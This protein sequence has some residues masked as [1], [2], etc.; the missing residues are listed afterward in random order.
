[1]DLLHETIRAHAERRPSKTALI[2]GGATLGYADLERNVRRLAGFLAARFPRGTRLG[3]LL[4]N[5]ASAVIG[6]YA[7]SAAGLVAVP[8]DADIHPRHADRL[9]EDCQLG[10]MLTT[11][12]CLTRVPLDIPFVI[13]ADGSRPTRNRVALEPILENARNGLLN[14]PAPSA[15]D[16]ACVLYTAGTTGRPKG[17]MLTHRNL[18]AAARN[19]IGFM[20]LDETVVES[21]PTRLSHSFGFARLRSVL[22]AGGTALLEPGFLRPERL[23]Q[24]LR[25]LGA[26]ALSSS[27]TGWAILLDHYLEAFKGLG[28]RLRFIEIG[29]ARLSRRHR[30]M[31]LELCPNARVVMH[32]GLTES[33]RATFIDLRTEG[34]RWGTAG[35]PAPGV[36][37][38]V[39]RE[40]GAEAVRGESGE[41]M[42]RAETNTPGYW[43]RADLTAQAL[44]NGWLRT[45]DLGFVDPDGYLHLS[46]RAEEMINLGGLKVSPVEVEEVLARQ[47]AIQE[48]AVVGVPAPAEVSGILIKAYLVAR[49]GV[50]FP[51][52]SALKRACLQELEA[53]KVPQEFEVVWALPKTDSGKIRKDLLA[54]RAGGRDE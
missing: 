4:P 40:D 18:G 20:G 36:E 43:G 28:P 24:R 19:I 16:V 54:A 12:R 17:V 49:E 21:L 39:V 30:D 48:A 51:A 22:Q 26:N 25:T 7:A 45:R 2:D 33:S 10:V 27:P 5:S 29:S 46:G 32:Y 53:Y 34:D 13:L 42:I 8:M 37:I 3:I 38:K 44:T 14:L 23:L 50:A 31:L 41:I 6:L 47:E 35:R 15:D 52:F 1:M 11:E 9:L